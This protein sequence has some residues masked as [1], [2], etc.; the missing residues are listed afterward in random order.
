MCRAPGT[1]TILARYR[2]YMWVKIRRA[3]GIA[4]PGRVNLAI[5]T[6]QTK[7][8]TIGHAAGGVF[9]PLALILSNSFI[10]SFGCDLSG[11]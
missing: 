11:L 2:S 8:G 5:L 4:L 10:T 7:R 1:V 9:P 3:A 6:R